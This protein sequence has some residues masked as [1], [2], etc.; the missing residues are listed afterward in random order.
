MP[1]KRP[2]DAFKKTDGC[3]KRR[4]FAYKEAGSNSMYAAGSEAGMLTRGRMY[5][6]CHDVG[7]YV[8]CA[9]VQED[10][11]ALISGCGVCVCVCVVCVL[12]VCVCVCA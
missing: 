10:C 9:A 12:C 3:L 11:V 4:T 7:W 1:L 8:R 6:G 2:T 5:A